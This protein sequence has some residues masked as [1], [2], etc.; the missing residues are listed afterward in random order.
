M[1]LAEFWES[2]PWELRVLTQA[3]ADKTRD[4][5]EVHAGLIASLMNVTQQ[6]KRPKKWTVAKLIGN[7]RGRVDASTVNSLGEFKDKIK[8]L[9][10]ESKDDTVW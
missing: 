2:N 3:Y 5:Q 6:L 7:R 1:S 4:T 10:E 8:E 9:Q